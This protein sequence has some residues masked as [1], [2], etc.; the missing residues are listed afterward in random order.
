LLQEILELGPFTV[1][2]KPF[3]PGQVAETAKMCA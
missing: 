2:V 1:L 3:R